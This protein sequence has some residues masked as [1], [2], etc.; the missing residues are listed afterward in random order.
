MEI[1]N[2][3]QSYEQEIINKTKKATIRLGDKTDKYRDG[4]QVMIA[5]V[6]HDFRQDKIGEAIIEKSYSKQL[7]DLVE[8]DLAG[9]SED[10]NS[11]EKLKLALSKLHGVPIGNNALVTV[12]KFYF[13]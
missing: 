4:Q 3:H 5:V 12:I 1:L 13:I 11:R 7:K 2:F 6:K 8:E 9:E 10:V